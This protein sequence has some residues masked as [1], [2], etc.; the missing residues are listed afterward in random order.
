MG[1]IQSAVRKCFGK[2]EDKNEF[3]RNRTNGASIVKEDPDGPLDLSRYIFYN[4]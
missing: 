3:V 1:A 2:S 4:Q